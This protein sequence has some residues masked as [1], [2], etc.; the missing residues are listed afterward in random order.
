MITYDHFSGMVIIIM[1]KTDGHNFMTNSFGHW[2]YDQLTWRNYDQIRR[3]QIRIS[4]VHTAPLHG[5][6]QKKRPILFFSLQ[7]LVELTSSDQYFSPFTIW[8]STFLQSI[9]IY[10]VRP[11]QVHFVF[12]SNI[13]TFNFGR[14]SNSCWAEAFLQPKYFENVFF[15]FTLDNSCMGLK[16]VQP[17]CAAS[18]NSNQNTQKIPINLKSQHIFHKPNYDDISHR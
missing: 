5:P 6:S 11:F 7:F 4:P 1:T 18:Q 3:S 13:V 2:L 14:E 17:N 15:S 8:A 16:P 10:A 12:S 9:P